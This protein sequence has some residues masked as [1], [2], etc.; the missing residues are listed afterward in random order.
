MNFSTFIKPT[1]FVAAM[2]LAG[3][4]S[5]ATYNLGALAAGDTYLSGDEG[6][7]VSVAKGSFTDIFN[8]SVGNSTLDASVGIINFGKFKISGASFSY[9]LK[10]GAAT[11]ATGVNDAGFAGQSLAA[12]SY[13]LEVSGLASGAGGGKYNGVLTVTAVPEPESYAMLLAGLGL[14]GAIAKRRKAKQA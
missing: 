3:M 2:A 4:A 6:S 9:S 14:M 8:F 13:S 5:A 11:L 7:L 10:S 1:V 12:G